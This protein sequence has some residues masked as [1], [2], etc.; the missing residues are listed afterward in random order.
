MNRQI[1]TVKRIGAGFIVSGLRVFSCYPLGEGVVSLRARIDGVPKNIRVGKEA[2]VRREAWLTCQKDSS[3]N[4]GE[5]TSISSYVKIKSTNAGYVNI[6]KHCN[7][8]SFGVIYGDGGVTIG[9]HVRI[10]THTVIV[11]NNHQFDDANKNIYEQG[12]ERK[13]IV[14]KDDVWI[15][16]HV[17]IL[18]GVTIGAHAVVAA[19]AV[20]TKDVP[21]NAVVAGVPAKILRYRGEK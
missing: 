19:G 10:A 12:T 14:I 6:G 11:P 2:R 3:I 20:V 13:P 4:I 9:D 21:E 1:E 7:I 17:T 8:H 16:A 15:G 5:G 18:A